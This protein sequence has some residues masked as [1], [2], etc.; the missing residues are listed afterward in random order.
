M[1]NLALGGWSPVQDGQELT[2]QQYPSNPS[3]PKVW[4]EMTGLRWSYGNTTSGSH[5]G[6]ISLYFHGFHDI[7]GHLWPLRSIHPGRRGLCLQPLD[8]ERDLPGMARHGLWG[9]A[10]EI[11]HH[12][13][14]SNEHQWTIQWTIHWHQPLN[15]VYHY[16]PPITV[17]GASWC[18]LNMMIYGVPGRVPMGTF[19]SEH[20]QLQG[21]VYRSSM[22]SRHLGSRS[23]TKTQHLGIVGKDDSLKLTNGCSVNVLPGGNPTRLPTI[24][25]FVSAVAFGCGTCLCFNASSLHAF[26]CLVAPDVVH[27]HLWLAPA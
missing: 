6:S 15:T 22:M 17:N 8:L 21:R 23:K 1:L 25:G 14:I 24:A 18:L 3:V 11:A 10:G 4:T 16:W 19:S 2:V 26:V 7:F 5:M 9:E 13:T 27:A 20:Q 12:F